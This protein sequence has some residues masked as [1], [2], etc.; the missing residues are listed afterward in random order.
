MLTKLRI[1]AMA[2][3]ATIAI[4]STPWF[5]N[6]DDYGVGYPNSGFR[7]DSEVH[8]WCY[9]ADFGEGLVARG[10]VTYAMNNLDVQTTMS[11]SYTSNCATDSGTDARWTRETDLLVEGSYTCM[12]FT[13]ANYRCNMADLALNWAYMDTVAN[14][15]QTACHEVGHSVGLTHSTTNC[16]GTDSDDQHYSLHQTFHI[17]Y[18][19]F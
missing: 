6:A 4:V 17:N 7:S 1:T 18:D 14:W 13:T 15:R 3:L 8:I 9:R 10:A 2:T 19:Q 12:I 16:M 5:A 11:D